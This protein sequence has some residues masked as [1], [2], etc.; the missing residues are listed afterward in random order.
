[1]DHELHVTEWGAPSA[2]PIFMWHGLARTGRDFDEL[3]A[4]LS[5][6][7]F[8][9]CPDMIGRGL[10]TWAD[11]PEA[12]YSIEFYTGVAADLMDHYGIAQAGWIGT[13]MGGM[14]GMRLA[15]GPQAHRLSWLIVNDIGPE[16]PQEAIDR[17]LSY[18]GALPVFD[19]P[20]EAQS[21]LE[22]AYAPFGPADEAFWTRMTRT[23]LR[24]CAD[25]RM[26][27]HYDPRIL[28]Q[29]TASADELTSWDRYEKIT[30]PTHIIRGADSDILLSGI[31]ALMKAKGPR[32]ELSV[33]EGCGH[34]P[35]LCTKEQIA[36]VANIIRRF[37]STNF[38]LAATK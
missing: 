21:W 38:S 11:V 30:T 28:V 3:A 26:T 29:F 10:S 5:A 12:E 27:L 31:A 23:S 36:L 16:V 13:S 20:R 35:T 33:I 14:I 7:H 34:A 1:M 8:V 4:A 22:A 9:I 32:P 2:P 37:N 25:G 19:T 18:V 15:A 6:D 17:I 24:R